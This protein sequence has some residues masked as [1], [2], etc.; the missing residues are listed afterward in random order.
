MHEV[1]R[2]SLPP[3]GPDG[4][5]DHAAPAP[6]RARLFVAHPSNNTVEVIDIE[7][8][9]HRRSI[10]GLRG[11]AGVWVDDREGLLFT[12][13]RAEDTA[14]IFRIDEDGERELHR[15]PTGVRPNGLAFDARRG[16]VMVAGVGDANRA[17]A[18]P[19]LTF[20]EARTG[21]VLQRT[22]MPGRTRWATYH[23]PSDAYFVNIADPAVIA[24]IDGENLATVARTYAV[25]A[26][27]PHGLEATPDG[28]RIYC[29]CDD[30]QLVELDLVT[31][32]I[33]VVGSLTGPPDVLWSDP[34]ANRLYA[35][36]G[37]PGCVDVFALDSGRRV[38]T[39]RS[40]VGAHT[41]TVDRGR[42]EVHV[43]LP[44]SHEDLVLGG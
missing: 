27:G 21:G 22:P 25:P 38:E 7:H 44:E 43:F 23:E 11:V 5:F 34:A 16:V 15:V 42:S 41:L 14:C 33:R 17:G 32:R 4:E 19:T 37:T 30:G 6:S 13:N 3:H 31:A 2:V 40:G 29:A 10:S 18:P 9:R 26:Q 24:R 28:H 1:A 39:V 35:A 36:I 20:A 12:S 8:R